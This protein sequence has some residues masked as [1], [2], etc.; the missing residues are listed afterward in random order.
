MV[1]ARRQDRRCQAKPKGTE[2]GKQGGSTEKTSEFSR[3]RVLLLCNT[4]DDI[5]PALPKK[6]NIPKSSSTVC[7]KDTEASLF[8]V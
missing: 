3:S 4:V 2:R 6:R 5:I 7:C 8:K 1:A